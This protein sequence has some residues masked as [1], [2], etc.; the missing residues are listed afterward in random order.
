MRATDGVVA[1]SA[2]HASKSGWKNPDRW[3]NDEVIP[4]MIRKQEI[5]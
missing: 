5:S 2:F 1:I 3:K 4:W